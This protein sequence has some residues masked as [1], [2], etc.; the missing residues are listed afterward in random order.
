MR[1]I[2]RMR[3][4]FCF[5]KLSIT[6]PSLTLPRYS[7][8]AQIPGWLSSNTHPIRIFFSPV[9]RENAQ[10]PDHVSGCPAPQLL[11]L[12]T[13]PCSFTG[14]GTPRHVQPLVIPAFPVVHD[15]TFALT[16]SQSWNSP[17]TPTWTVRSI[18]VPKSQHSGSHLPRLLWVFAGSH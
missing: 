5:C 2:L 3:M 8:P 4:G 13:L 7:S 16:A 14:S 18:H 12:L 1:N 9:S 10:A 6:F 15:P 17:Q 11:A